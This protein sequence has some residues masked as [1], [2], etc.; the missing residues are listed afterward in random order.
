GV[1]KKQGRSVTELVSPL[2]FSWGSNNEALPAG[3]VR[4]GVRCGQTQAVATGE[5]QRPERSTCREN[6]Q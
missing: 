2:L 5:G 1:A 3:V 4:E 6:S